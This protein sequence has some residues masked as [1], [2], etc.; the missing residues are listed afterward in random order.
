[1]IAAPVALASACTALLSGSD[2]GSV[3]EAGP[4]EGGD[5]LARDDA[6]AEAAPTTDAAVAGDAADVEVGPPPTVEA[7]SAW[8]A[9]A[10][11]VLSN[12]RLLCWGNDAQS[13]LGDG[14]GSG[15]L[16]PTLVSLSNGGPLDGVS[17]VAVGWKHACALRGSAILCWG[18]QAW[19]E[20]G[21]T[22][23]QTPQGH[24]DP[25]HAAPGAFTS[26]VAKGWDGSS[27]DPLGGITC[28]TDSSHS[29]LCWGS[30]A[31]DALGHLPGSNGD[32]TVHDADAGADVVANSTP[33]FVT[34][35]SDVQQ[36]ALFDGGGCAVT[37]SGAVKCWG[38]NAFGELA[39]GAPGD[40]PDAGAVLI[41]P[42]QPLTGVRKVYGGHDAVCALQTTGTLWCWGRNDAFSFGLGPDAGAPA[43]PPTIYANGSL[44]PIADVAI[45]RRHI[46]VIRASDSTVWCSGWNAE[47]E[48]G[49]GF[50]GAGS[51][52]SPIGPC[53]A[54]PVQVIATELGGILPGALELSAGWSSTCARTKTGVYCWGPNGYGETGHPRGYP[55]DRPCNGASYCTPVATGVQL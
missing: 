5:A 35:L 8:Y 47:Y 29:V 23:S 51:D 16:A 27:N 52:A 26:V 18:D 7:L 2:T 15:S 30:N 41:A 55:P 14:T 20:T 34:A 1:V 43:T 46:C 48:L 13:A 10:C 39:N 25:Y 11:A 45:G 32:V 31:D 54:T 44:G 21:I 17:Q 33:V 28:A 19:G 6:G 36:L 3:S 37:A 38:W 50:A 22:M 42:N 40:S 49:A 53:V 9:H 12:G 4:L 24:P